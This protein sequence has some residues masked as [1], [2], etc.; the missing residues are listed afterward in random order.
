MIKIEYLV[1][2]NNDETPIILADNGSL[3]NKI[4]TK[5]IGILEGNYYN[6]F[7]VTPASFGDK[8]IVVVNLDAK[9]LVNLFSKTHIH[10]V[11]T[12]K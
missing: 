6:G 4:H 11:I 2:I 7:K 8:K 9:V 1:F 10:N 3:Y 12:I 5:P